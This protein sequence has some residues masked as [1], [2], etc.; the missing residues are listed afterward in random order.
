MQRCDRI[1]YPPCKSHFMQEASSILGTVADLVAIGGFFSAVA[2]W[3]YSV[4]GKLNKIESIDGRLMVVEEKVT[5]LES[6]DKKLSQL[7]AI[8]VTQ[9]TING[10]SVGKLVS[11]F[12]PLKL[13]DA[14]KD[15]LNQSGLGEFMLAN[16]DV[17]IAEVLKREPKDA[18][19]IQQESMDIARE[20]TDMQI[21]DQA[22]VAQMRQFAFSKGMNVL[23]IL[24][25]AGIMLRDMVLE[26]KGIPIEEVDKHTPHPEA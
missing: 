21:M 20:M 11:S 13:T 17:L 5:R 7:I 26:H 8:L 3:F 14:G 10:E 25:A 2:L 6:T 18:Y 9:N 24:T 19:S 23:S 12:S 4:R 1:H 16:K 22:V 15:A